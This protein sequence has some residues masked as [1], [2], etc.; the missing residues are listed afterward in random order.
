VK[1]LGTWRRGRGASVE[2]WSKANFGIA[3]AIKG[4]EDSRLII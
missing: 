2:I 4:S 1:C 3:L